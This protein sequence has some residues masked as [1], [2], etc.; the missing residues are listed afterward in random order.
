MLTVLSDSWS[1]GCNLAAKNMYLNFAKPP[2]VPVVQIKDYFA[3]G[4]EC[5]MLKEIHPSLLLNVPSS[6]VCI[7]E[8]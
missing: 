5:P 2:A 6:N 1:Y 3:I 8:I 4:A 7:Y